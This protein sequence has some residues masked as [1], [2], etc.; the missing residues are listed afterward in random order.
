MTIRA[1]GLCL[2]VSVVS[3]VGAI[4]F[5]LGAAAATEDSAGG[6][7]VSGVIGVVLAAVFARSSR[8]GLR[9][10][11][12]RITVRGLSTTDQLARADVA[13][14]AVQRFARDK[15]MRLTVV[16]TD[17]TVVPVVWSVTRVTD[18]KWIAA[19]THAASGF[20]V[21]QEHVIPALHDAGRLAGQEAL[22]LVTA[23]PGLTP[24]TVGAAD[25]AGSVRWLGLET[26]F[27]MVAFAFPFV[28][29]AVVTLARHFGGV[30]D[31]NEFA[32]PLPHHVAASFFLLLLEYSTTA[33]MV[34]VALLLLAR[35]G[36][37]PAS[38]GLEARSWR[39]DG[40]GGVALLAGVWVANVA[41]LL[42]LS[43]VFN[44]KHLTNTASDSHVPAY[45]VIYGLTLAATTAINE[46]VLVN[47][48]FLTR[49]SQLGWSPR[50]AFAL[51]LTVRTSYHLYYGIGLLGTVPFGY[52]VTR[53]FQ[54]RGR[55]LRPIIT[56]FLYDAILITIAVLTS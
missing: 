48:Y 10:E 54:K 49:L 26:V 17:G 29:G 46:E 27:V 44:N 33:I 52:L 38:L 56:H 2:T 40:I 3:A 14:L 13:G 12:Q 35:T 34:P 30:S 45:Y 53:S 39:R 9:L 55:L 7:V 16:R 1:R 51:S 47:G 36:Q 43:F 23:D 21:T 18:Q 24:A 41:V 50:R 22:P 28:V 19:V 5:V 20:G 8:A 15:L 31:L 42:P 11:P 6:R 37:S 32:L 25:T 4:I